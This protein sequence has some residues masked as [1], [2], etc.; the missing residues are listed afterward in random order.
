MAHKIIAHRG[1]SKD[2]RENTLEAFDLAIQYGVDGIEFDVH[3]TLDQR[4]VVYHDDTLPTINKLHI[5]EIQYEIAKEILAAENIH[6]P[7]LNEVIDH[8][9]GQIFFDIELKSSVNHFTVLST[10]S[11][12]IEYDH[13]Q[14]KSFNIDLMKKI[15]DANNKIST[16]LVI[17]SN[18]FPP[19]NIFKK[20]KYCSP[21]QI[22]LHY[23]EVQRRYFNLMKYIQIPIWVWT[24]DDPTLM[25]KILKEK[26]IEG[27]ITNEPLRALNFQ[28]SFSF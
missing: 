5:S 10:L 2:R 24:V 13:Y 1:A 22:H 9:H 23:S 28:K 8:F 26:E 11:S 6:L 20:I 16:A 18:W 17:D 21:N 4:L 7:L 27:I 19:F 25:Y 12:Q 15:K 3:Q 14:L